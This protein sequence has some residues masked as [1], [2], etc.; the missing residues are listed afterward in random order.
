MLVLSRLLLEKIT[1][2]HYSFASSQGAIHVSIIWLTFFLVWPLKISVH[3]VELILRCYFPIIR[4]R[5]TLLLWYLSNIV[6][7]AVLLFHTLDLFLFHRSVLAYLC[8]GSR[9]ISRWLFVSWSH[10]HRFFERVF[11]FAT[12]PRPF[13]FA[14]T[15][16]LIPCCWVFV[17]IF[18]G[19]CLDSVNCTSD[20]FDVFEDRRLSFDEK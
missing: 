7:N 6:V 4:W 20:V 15:P 10:L 17:R 19:P 18:D 16:L 11:S 13:T 14:G 2:L 12:L 1:F 8:P 9:W 5:F 3:T